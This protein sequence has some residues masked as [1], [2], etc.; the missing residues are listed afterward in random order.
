[1]KTGF[2]SSVCKPAVERKYISCSCVV[3]AER[4]VIMR[5]C[6]FQTL[7]AKTLNMTG[8]EK[9][10]CYTDR[11]RKPEKDETTW[12]DDAFD[13]SYTEKDS[14]VPPAKIVWRNVVLMTILHVGAVYGLTLVPSAKPLTL[15]FGKF[16]VFFLDDS[17]RQY[18][19][20]DVM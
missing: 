6:L 2:E 7:Q 11:Q 9:T 8:T 20:H 13:E 17:M 10:D 1:M 19:D 12:V 15:L 5:L 3:V 16:W 14:S 18:I 4:I